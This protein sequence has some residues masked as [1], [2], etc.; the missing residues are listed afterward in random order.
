MGYAVVR[1][2]RTLLL[3]TEVSD[4]PIE[5]QQM[6][7]EFTDIVVDDLPDKLP[8]KRNISH[9]VDF[10]PGASFSNKATY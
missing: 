4:L 8:T 6:F 9:H 1:K 3:H 7:Q 2:E 10:I 5:I